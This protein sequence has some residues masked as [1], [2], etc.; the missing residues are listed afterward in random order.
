MIDI[1]KIIDTSKKKKVL[2]V[3][4]NK[5]ARESMIGLLTNIFS[6]ITIAVD[7]KDG[8]DKFYENKFSYDLIISDIN[9]PKMNGIEMVTQIKKEKEDIKVLLLSAY[10]ENEYPLDANLKID[11]RL[12]KPINFERLFEELNN[13]YSND[14]KGLS[15]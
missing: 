4:D 2:Y 7:G 6:D 14:I 5:D 10:S 13:L 15:M 12:N 3:E 9:M 1:Q 8:L 11:V